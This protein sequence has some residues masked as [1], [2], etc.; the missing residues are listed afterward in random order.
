MAYGWN[1]DHSGIKV[2]FLLRSNGT[3]LWGFVQGEDFFKRGCILT[4]CTS[5]W[6]KINIYRWH[7]WLRR[8]KTFTGVSSQRF[9]SVLLT[10]YISVLN[11]RGKKLVL[12]K[13]RAFF[14]LRC[15]RCVYII[16]PGGPDMVLWGAVSAT[17]VKSLAP[18]TYWVQVPFSF[19][20]TNSAKHL[21][22]FSKSSKALKC[23]KPDTNVKIMLWCWPVFLDRDTFR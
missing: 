19:H 10:I 2:S 14:L 21:R 9:I 8:Y 1:W 3:W 11:W 20:M 13:E 6:F 15:L 16:G 4:C 17:S 23:L 5:V 22:L 18:T 7:R 12:G